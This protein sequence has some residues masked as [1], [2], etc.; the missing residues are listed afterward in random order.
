MVGRPASG[1]RGGGE[2]ARCLCGRP[3]PD[4]H[5]RHRRRRLDSE[6]YGSSHPFWAWFFCHES[7]TG[8]LEPRETSKAEWNAAVLDLDLTQMPGTTA[9]QTFIRRSQPLRNGSK[10]AFEVRGYYTVTRE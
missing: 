7:N 5:R 1:G 4:L 6:L 10:V 3:D 8:T 9:T 2:R